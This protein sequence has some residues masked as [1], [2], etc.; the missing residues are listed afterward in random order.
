MPLAKKGQTR[1]GGLGMAAPNK[2]PWYNSATF[3]W[4]FAASFLCRDS[5]EPLQTAKSASVF[6]CKHVFFCNH[7]PYSICQLSSNHGKVLTEQKCWLLRLTSNFFF[8]ATFG[9]KLEWMILLCCFQRQEGTAGSVPNGCLC[10]EKDVDIFTWNPKHNC[11]HSTAK[12]PCGLL[13]SSETMQTQWHWA[14]FQ[15]R[16]HFTWHVSLENN[17]PHVSHLL[18]I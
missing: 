3:C 13:D 10:L 5:T 15:L 12:T 4:S 6:A 17:S 16:V 7:E 14:T 9:W 1:R 18:L 2:W 11:K 8:I